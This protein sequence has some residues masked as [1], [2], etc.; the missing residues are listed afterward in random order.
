MTASKTDNISALHDIGQPA[1]A[2][3]NLTPI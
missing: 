2:E 1:K 3:H